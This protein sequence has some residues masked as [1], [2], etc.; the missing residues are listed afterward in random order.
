MP[1]DMPTLVDFAKM[2]K[3]V[4]AAHGF[5]R[6]SSTWRRDTGEFVDIIEY[7]RGGP[8]Y[9][10]NIG[11]LTKSAYKVAWGTDAPQRP[12]ADDCTVEDRIKNLF[13]QASD[14]SVPMTD[15]MRAKRR[16]W[17]EL[18]DPKSHA[19]I[20]GLI[21]QSVL[22]FFEQMHSRRAQ[23]D[24]LRRGIGGAAHWLAPMSIEILRYECGEHLEACANLRNYKGKGKYATYPDERAN[25]I[26]DRLNCL[27]L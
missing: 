24:Y 6:A 19:E 13:L 23:I 12:H 11:V 22:P 18:S 26:A 2:L 25:A 1:K 20:I 17:W 7:Q 10:L 5:V 16:Q 8:Q 3:S 4:V 14:L 15:E 9:T 21:E 27:K